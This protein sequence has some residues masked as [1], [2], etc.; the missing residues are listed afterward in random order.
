MKELFLFSGLGADRRV[1]EFLDLSGY[2]LHY[3][4]WIEPK[5]RESIEEYAKRLLPQITEPN[6]ILLGVSFGGMIA[7]EVGKLIQTEKII[8]I[9]S[10]KTKSDIPALYSIIGRLKIHKL[11]PV[12]LMK[13][14]PAFANW[15]FGVK[16][17]CDRKLLN[18]IIQETD[19]IFLPWA[20]NTITNWNNETGLPNITHIHGTNDHILPS[21]EANYLI[22]DGGHFMIVNR[23]SEVSKII[24]KILALINDKPF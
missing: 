1:F 5:K 11:L 7:V 18:R 2:R 14:L 19:E 16:S 4:E 10:A 22:K 3:I 13:K 21:K 6:P 20:I 8:L 23:A 12:N 17:E 9:S 24:H 15:F